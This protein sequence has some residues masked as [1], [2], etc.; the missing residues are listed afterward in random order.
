[1]GKSKAINDRDIRPGR[2]QAEE[3]VRT[4]I[5]WAGDDPAR[6]GLR[7]TPAR[8][9][10]FYRDFF[11]GYDLCAEEFSASTAPGAAGGDIVLVGGI[12]IAT[13][14][15]HHMLPAEGTASVAY[16]PGAAVAGLGAVARI[17]QYCAARLTTQEDL[18]AAI[19]QAMEQAFAPHGVAVLTRLRHGC[20][21]LRASGQ[22]GSAATVL[23]YAGVFCDDMALQNRFLALAGQS[24]GDEAGT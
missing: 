3:A 8:V 10:D 14:C 18:T 23:R 22:Q 11:K 6:A 13:F 1:M 20:M 4:L 16:I 24:G 9:A 17:A 21:T 5:R 2:A 12:A 15:E 19:A 7:Q